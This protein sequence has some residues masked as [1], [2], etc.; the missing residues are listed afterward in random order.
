MA[1][2][3]Q[4]QDYLK[5]IEAQ[6]GEMKK[7]VE[8][9]LMT[10]GGK[11]LFRHLHDTCGFSLSSIVIN[12]KTGEVDTVATTFNE[13]RRAVYIELR[14]LAPRELLREIEYTEEKK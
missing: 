13:S 2:E 11:K 10:D 6:R 4:R 7:V 3:E 5:K 8:S 9:V 14:G 12:I 1:T